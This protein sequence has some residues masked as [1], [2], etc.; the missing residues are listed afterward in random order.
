VLALRVEGGVKSFGFVGIGDVTVSHAE[1]EVGADISITRKDW[2]TDPAAYRHS[3][4]RSVQEAISACV[5]KLKKEKL[6]VD[7]QR[8]KRDLAQVQREFLVATNISGLMLK[9]YKRL[10]DKLLYWEAWNDANEVVVHWG[11][12][13]D[14]GD[15]RVVVLR[16]GDDPSSIIQQEAKIPRAEGYDTIGSEKLSRLTIQYKISGMGTVDDLDKRHRVENVM[17]DCLGWTGL[18]HCDGGDIGSGTMNVFCFI[19]DTKL[20]LQITVKELKAKGFLE[21]AV[22]AGASDAGYRVMWPEHFRGKF[23]I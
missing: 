14:R 18:G 15:S 6:V 13:G 7:E 22:I 3:L 10:E 1:Q 12:V 20:A 17:N 9:L 4:W 19:V 11:S 23:S 2:M 5:G 21:G 16:A 8:L